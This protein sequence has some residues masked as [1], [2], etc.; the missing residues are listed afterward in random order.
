MDQAVDFLICKRYGCGAGALP[1]PRGPGFQIGNRGGSLAPRVEQ[2]AHLLRRHNE[3]SG[4]AMAG[5]GHRFALRSIEQLT[6][7]VLRLH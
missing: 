5:Y 7:T 4:S 6:E 3:C 1:R 2:I